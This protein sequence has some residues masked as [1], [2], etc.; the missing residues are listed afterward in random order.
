MPPAKKKCW[1]AIAVYL[2][3]LIV[4]V[5]FFA[6]NLKDPFFIIGLIGSLILTF[7]WSIINVFLLWGLAHGVEGF[8]ELFAVMFLIFGIINS[9]LILIIFDRKQTA[10]MP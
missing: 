2:S 9:G 1:V 6:F 7:P 4:C 3:A 10:E 8:Q 5:S